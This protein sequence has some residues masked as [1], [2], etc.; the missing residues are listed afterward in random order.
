VIS[1]LLSVPF[2]DRG[3][4]AFLRGDPVFSDRVALPAQFLDREAPSPIL[5]LLHALLLLV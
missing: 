3:L 2:P 4:A 5:L 1:H